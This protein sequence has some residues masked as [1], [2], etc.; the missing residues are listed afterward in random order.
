MLQIAQKIV[1]LKGA[2]GWEV[3][4]ATSQADAPHMSP[5]AI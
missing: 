5:Q 3:I 4:T 2:L 1:L